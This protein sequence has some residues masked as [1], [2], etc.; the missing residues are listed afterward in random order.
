VE[1]FLFDWQTGEI[2]AYILAGDIATPFGDRAVLFPEDVETIVAEAMIV[3]EGGEDCLKSES[4]GLKG[5]LSE[6]SRQ[7]QDLVHTMG[8][9]LHDLISPQD[10]PEIVRVKIKDESDELA[11]S[12]HH[13]R[14]ALQEATD[15]L[16]HQWESLQHSISRAG[17]R[18]KSALDRAWTNLAGKT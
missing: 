6:K 11:A 3:R 4:E 8:D 7:V 14:H 16:H 5:F 15:F 9:R 12:G 18:A 2:S 10:R 1:D 13:D 17:Q